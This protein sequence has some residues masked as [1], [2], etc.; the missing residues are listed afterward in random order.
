VLIRRQTQ[1]ARSLDDFLRTFFG[2]A[3][4]PPS[5]S[6]YQLDDVLKALGTVAPHDWSGFFA[7]RVERIRAAPPVAGV[8]AGG[9][10]IATAPEPSPF[11]K[12]MAAASGVS[13]LTASLGVVLSKANLILDVVP[14]SPA[15]RAGVPTSSKL[16]GVNGR[17]LT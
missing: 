14:G 1:G 9:W 2:G 8:V 12:G 4:G 16:L 15:D 13:D 17:A 3:S 5:V 7:E 6:A 10:L 11:A